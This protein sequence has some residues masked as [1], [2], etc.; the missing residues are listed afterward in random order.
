M[1]IEMVNFALMLALLAVPLLSLVVYIELS[2][3]RELKEHKRKYYRG[4]K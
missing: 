1:S 3:R 2:Q 4:V